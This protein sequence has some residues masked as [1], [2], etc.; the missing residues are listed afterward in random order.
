MPKLFD[1][2]PISFR[3]SWNQ[4]LRWTKGNYQVFGRYGRKLAVG[5]LAK[6]SFSCYDMM[7]NVSPAMFVTFASI[8][9]N[10]IFLYGRYL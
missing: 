1:E 6:R 2:Q 7:M 10:G 5:V 4:R 8:L 3:Q 9:F